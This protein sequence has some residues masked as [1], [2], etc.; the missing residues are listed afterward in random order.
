MNEIY[1]LT[2]KIDDTVELIK[3][4]KISEIEKNKFIEFLK[5]IVSRKDFSSYCCVCFFRDI[6]TKELYDFLLQELKESVFCN[7]PL[8]IE[9]MKIITIGD[10]PEYYVFLDEVKNNESL[11]K[12]F[13]LFINKTLDLHNGRTTNLSF[14]LLNRRDAQ[15]E[16]IDI[17]WN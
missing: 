9:I 11:S 16:H 15:S 12:D 7:V 8:S 2:R 1:D 6:M 4:N 5:E 14:P 17:V 13:L 10:F 3:Q